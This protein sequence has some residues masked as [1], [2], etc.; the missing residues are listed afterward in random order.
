MAVAPPLLVAAPTIT[1]AR[2]GLASASDLVVE[3][4]PH[5]RNGIEFEANPT[6]A[7]K[8]SRA[9]CGQDTT[10][11]FDT[12]VPIVDAGPISVYQGFTC[13]AVGLSEDEILDRARRALSG[14]EWA[15][16]EKAV[17]DSAELR[18]MGPDTQVVTTDPVPLV[19]GVALLEE[20][21]SDE[22]GGVGVLH[23]TR[24]VAPFAAERRQVESESGRKVTT[25]GTRWSFGNYPN[26]T[27]DGTLAATDTA[28]IVATGAV[29]VRRTDV[30]YRNVA[31]VR[32]GDRYAI[33]ERTYV[34]SWESVTAAALVTLT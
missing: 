10:N 1:P 23:A 4:N 22:Y 24:G 6:G 8:L 29:Q 25:L 17:W 33:A 34:V 26:T 27:Q 21:L 19:K 11:E 5:V 3:P 9:E 31:D 18:L 12:G 28:W 15:A 2:Y 32:G 13:S 16:V 30:S 7:A 20:V 14:G